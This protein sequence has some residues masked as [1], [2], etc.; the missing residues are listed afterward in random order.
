[1]INLQVL[2][3]DFISLCCDIF[4]EI[5]ILLQITGQKRSGIKCV[6]MAKTQNKRYRTKTKLKNLSNTTLN[7]CNVFLS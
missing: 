5:V 1:M 3:V 7:R 2:L 6:C 4:D